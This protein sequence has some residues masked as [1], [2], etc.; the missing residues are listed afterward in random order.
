M[1]T[2][3]RRSARASS[4]AS[5]TPAP[6]AATPATTTGVR[7]R[8]RA[9]PDTGA[10]LPAIPVGDNFSYG[11]QGRV[12]LGGQ[13]TRAPSGLFRDHLATA[14]ANAAAAP[15]DDEDEPPTSPAPSGSR[16]RKP[17]KAP[18]KPP[19]RAPSAASS[20][21][22]R[23]SRRTTVNVDRAISEEPED[24]QI[25][26]NQVEESSEG[27]EEDAE[28]GEDDENPPSVEPVRTSARDYTINNFTQTNV[29]ETF[30][31][32]AP[33]ASNYAS[34]LQNNASRLFVRNGVTA[35]GAGAQAP[36]P[37]I[38]R[39]LPVNTPVSGRLDP[40]ATADEIDAARPWVVRVVKETIPRWWDEAGSYIRGIVCL[41]ILCW[42]FLF[43]LAM[44]LMRLLPASI[45]IPGTFNNLADAIA[46]QA[47]KARNATMHNT[48]FDHGLHAR[49]D[50]VESDVKNL[51]VQ[52]SQFKDIL[53]EQFMVAKNPNTNT[54]DIPP[55]FWTAI[56][57]KLN[58]EYSLTPG[59]SPGAAPAWE[60][61]VAANH[62]KVESLISS[63][64]STAATSHLN[65]LSSSGT[66][67]SKDMFIA[68]LDEHTASL[69]REMA[70]LRLD[71]SRTA[72][73]I[74]SSVAASLPSRQT[75]STSA[76][77]YL[78][79]ITLLTLARNH[80][81]FRERNFLSAGL[82]AVID[83]YLSSPTYH[84]PQ[85]NILA[86]LFTYLPFTSVPGPNPPVTALMPWQE[87][88]DCWCAATSTTQGQAQLAALVVAPIDPSA[89]V[90]EHVPA[91]STLDIASAP[92][93]MEVWGLPSATILK[94]PT[95]NDKDR[96]GDCVGPEPEEGKGWTC[97]GRAAYDLHAQNWV[98]TFPLD[99]QGQM[100]AKVV[101]RAL[102]NWGAKRTCFYRVRLLG[103][104]VDEVVGEMGG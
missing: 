48:A 75:P 83:P 104:T 100:V 98:Q 79:D 8:A 20:N 56:E 71:A 63:S 43:P 25:I 96:K 19:S 29:D 94:A 52:W 78:E 3:L 21:A 17:S 31:Y 46:E 40:P 42:F 86:T 89:L 38:S 50:T 49:V 53:P 37:S 99:G 44:L 14:R 77:A 91:M 72:H 39:P 51:Q 5:Q 97:L 57:S 30:S 4:R 101:V 102:G 84:H 68:A 81:L 76:P 70:A 24:E 11:S 13:V 15:N 7:R 66:I 62:K 2:P 80:L 36:T 69:R 10:D 60:S 61:F 90:V 9:Q 85:P 95:L 16:S 58:S 35:S 32:V 26:L 92:R 22:S 65:R 45:D 12:E 59:S 34:Q 82:G 103:R 93:E 28:E 54:W 64:A 74:A 27:S 23:R 1:T 88:G 73:T 6:A 33:D 41:T 18:S 67:I 87:T 55:T 47:A